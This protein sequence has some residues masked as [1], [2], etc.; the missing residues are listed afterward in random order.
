MKYIIAITTENGKQKQRT[1]KSDRFATAKPYYKDCAQL[2]LGYFIWFCQILA[3]K[4]NFS[5]DITSMDL[6]DKAIALLQTN[7]SPGR[8]N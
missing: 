4:R 2:S 7:T 6:N 1:S 8:Y 5:E 3:I